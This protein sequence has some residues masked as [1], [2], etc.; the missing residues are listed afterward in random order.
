[1]PRD[2]CFFSLLPNYFYPLPQLKKKKIA[3][4]TVHL[5]DIPQEFN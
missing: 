5:E 2:P 1:M 3:S 4:A